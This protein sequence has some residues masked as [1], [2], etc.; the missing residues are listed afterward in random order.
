[1]IQFNLLPDIKVQY[2]KA[3]KAKRMVM[4]ISVISVIASLSLLIIMI[5]VTVFQNRHINYL[6]KDIKSYT[7]AIKNTEDVEKILTIQKQLEGLPDLYSIRPVTTRLFKYIQTT[8]PTQVSITHITI[9]FE[10]GLMSIDGSTDTLESINRYVDTLK[11]TTFNVKDVEGST[12][13]FK[14]VV[15]GS[16]GRSPQ[17]ATF[18]VKFKFNIDIFDSSKEIE[19]NVPKTITT[20]SE[21]ELP[22]SG[23][24]DSKGTN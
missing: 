6:N 14:E 15:L 7:N 19:L 23:V 22:G 21:T 20:R 24:F 13:A 11:F 3:K 4:A 8:T 18:S 16:F 1:M 12:N 17:L 9:D 5:S 2:I 10:E